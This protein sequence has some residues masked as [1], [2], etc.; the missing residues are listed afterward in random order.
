MIKDFTG[1]RISDDGSVWSAYMADAAGAIT[2]PRA[3]A[4]EIF[5][6]CVVCRKYGRTSAELA[7]ICRCDAYVRA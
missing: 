4:G 3:K 1:Y 2:I 6:W 7:A 5:H